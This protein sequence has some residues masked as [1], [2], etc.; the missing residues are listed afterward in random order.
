[1]ST[2]SLRIALVGYGKMGKTIEKIAL[3]RG[4]T[5]SQK[6]GSTDDVSAVNNSNTDVAIEFSRPEA[7]YSNLSKLM[8]SKTPTICGTTGWLEKQSEIEALCTKNRTS[9]L[10]A[11]NFSI[12]VNVFFELNKVLAKSMASLA[13]YGVDMQEIHHLQKLDAPSGTAITLAEQIMH[14]I[15]ELKSWSLTDNDPES[16]YIDAQRE[17]NV[18]GTHVINYTSSI[19]QISIKHEAFSRDGFALGAVIAAEFIA[20]KQGIFN[21]ND[22]L[23][24]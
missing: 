5:I 15:P 19:D 16:I 14:E 23:K 20:E 12:G 6:L 8:E 4:H 2:K 7:A 10:Y 11:S 9:F 17:P 22:V 18:P 13:E 21:M 3:E 1:M 24:L